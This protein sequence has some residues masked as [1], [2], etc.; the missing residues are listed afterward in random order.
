MEIGKSLQHSN[1]FFV[2]YAL[3]IHSVLLVS[4][5][6]LFFY[7][8]ILVNSNFWFFCF[9]AGVSE[10]KM[11]IFFWNPIFEIFQFN[12]LDK[13]LNE[14]WGISWTKTQKITTY[15][16]ALQMKAFFQIPDLKLLQFYHFSKIAKMVLLT[17]GWILFF[18]QMLKILG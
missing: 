16:L 18:G 2:G 6:Y 17:H 3:A 5:L 9:L 1:R 11:W 12:H 7:W 4:W 15:S 10:Q 8:P 13:H 14:A